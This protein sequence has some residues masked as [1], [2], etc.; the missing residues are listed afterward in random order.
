ML[1]YIYIYMWLYEMYLMYVCLLQLI[2]E[3]PFYYVEE[4]KWLLL[5]F[6]TIDERI[7]LTYILGIVICF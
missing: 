4:D 2:S 5:I 7:K 3:W 1:M 6:T